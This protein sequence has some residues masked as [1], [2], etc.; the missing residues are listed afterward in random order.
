MIKQA[1]D[2]VKLLKEHLIVDDEQAITLL[3]AT[4]AAHKIEGEMLWLRLIGSPGTGKTELLSSLSSVEGYCER[5]ESLTPASIRRGYIPDTKER[6]PTLLERINGKLV[7]TKELAPLLTS[8][9]ELKVE[10]FGL[11]RSVHDGEIVADY[12]SRQGCIIQK[13]RFDWILGSTRYIDRQ[14]ALEAHLGSRFIDLRWGA[15]IDKRLAVTRAVDNDGGLP[16]IRQSLAEAIRLL[17]DSI[18]PKALKPI[19]FDDFLPDLA[20]FVAQ[21]RTPV[22]RDRQNKEHIVD[23][24]DIELGTRVGQAFARITKGLALIGIVDY[25]P[26]L[27]R[28]ALDCLP[29]LRAKFVKGLLAGCKTEQELGNFM[30][31]SQVTAHYAKDDLKYLGFTPDQLDLVSENSH[32]PDIANALKV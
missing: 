2:Y 32:I 10:V 21:Y 31:V 25:K 20:N 3:L 19:Q 27:R 16:S 4:A 28:L 14:A 12:G 8:C 26:Y 1:T 18:K 5:I 17:L 13:T 30:A 22:D 24:P 11:L 29:P 23:L 9:R 7:I 6:L 15:P